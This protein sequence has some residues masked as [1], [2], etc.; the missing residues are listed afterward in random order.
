M[1]LSNVQKKSGLNSRFVN[2]YLID[3]FPNE[4]LKDWYPVMPKLPKAVSLSHFLV[5][6]SIDI[7]GFYSK[8]SKRL[9]FFPEYIPTANYIF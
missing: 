3:D 2:K 5:T 6:I 9:S 4:D 7:K 8:I 1:A